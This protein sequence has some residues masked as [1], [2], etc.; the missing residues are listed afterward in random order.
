MRSGTHGEKRLG[1]DSLEA[2]QD[3]NRGWWERTP[4]T[5]D[6]TAVAPGDRTLAWFD[7]QDRLNVEAH[8]FFATD[9]VPF[10]RLI[11]FG[12]LRG[13]RVL[14]IGV[15]AG[16]HA[17]LMARA[18]AD[19][20]GID[21]TDAAIATAQRRFELK[22]LDARFLRWDAEQPYHEFERGFDFIWSWGVIHH[23][24]R[25]G[26]IVRNVASWL[27][28]PG[29]FAGMVYHRESMS[30]AAAVVLD[31]VLRG[32]LWSGSIDETL[33]RS[34]DGFTARFYPSELWRDFLLG[35][36]EDATVAVSGLESDILP[37][38]RAL[39]KTLLRRISPRHARA[40]LARWGSFVTFEAARPLHT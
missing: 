23:S 39:R 19:V 27:K 26:R 21:L 31:G 6:W 35:F 28:D 17:E 18:G 4:M 3:R 34:T 25:T 20:T 11:P 1:S 38:P 30:A 2:V 37:V 29:R 14:E 5:Y 36:F 7:E 32:K 40:L 22:R 15:G 9:R 16:F 12:S 33:W 24:A 13:K 10:D 8:R